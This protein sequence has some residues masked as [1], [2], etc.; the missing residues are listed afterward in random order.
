MVVTCPNCDAKYSLDESRIPGR[1]ART[2]CQKCSHVFTIYK[3]GDWDLEPDPTAE[4]P[5]KASDLDV[6]SLD[7]QKVGIKSWKVKVNSKF[8]L[9]YDFSDYKTLHRYIREGKVSTTDLIGHDGQNWVCIDDIPDL[10]L[11]FCEVYLE[12]KLGQL[13]GEPESEAPEAPKSNV[14]S[15][16]IGELAS[17][18]A[19]AQAEVEDREVLSPPETRPRS[20]NRKRKKRKL[21]DPPARKSSAKLW[22]AALGMAGVLVFGL[23]RSQNTEEEVVPAPSAK[24]EKAS[25]QPTPADKKAEA[26]RA[27]LQK[28]LEAAAKKVKAELPTEGADGQ[29][30]VRIPQEILDQQAGNAGGP[31]VAAPPAAKTA[32]DFRRQGDL[33]IQKEDWKAAAEAYKQAAQL[34]PDP[35]LQERWGMALYRSGNSALARPLLSRARQ[36]GVLSASKWLGFISRDEGDIAGSNQFFNAYLASGPADAA[37]IRQVM[38]GR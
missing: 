26:L 5:S 23:T 37:Q 21:P 28:E 34:S 11:H 30:R 29:L 12:K 4:L 35:V 2:T 3:D 22:V 32:S 9:V 6:H 13:S 14:V 19:E 31:G 1:G 24:D 8:G 10:E 38:N 27:E 20:T 25:L 17:V 15:S 7:F 18:L 36:A 33:A 16:G